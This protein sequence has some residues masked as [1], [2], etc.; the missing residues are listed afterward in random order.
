[1]LDVALLPLRIQWYHV[2]R[3]LHMRTVE[4]CNWCELQAEREWAWSKAHE[5][6]LLFWADMWRLFVS[7]ILWCIYMAVTPATVAFMLP[8]L[9]HAFVMAEDW[10]SFTRTGSFVTFVLFFFI[11]FPWGTPVR[12]V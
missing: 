1:M 11:K 10:E 5:P 4:Y 2:Q 9:L 8:V 12:L 6:E 3:W 7:V